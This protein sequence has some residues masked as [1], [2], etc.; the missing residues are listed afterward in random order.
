MPET[1]EHKEKTIIS[2]GC[3]IERRKIHPYCDFTV[4]IFNPIASNVKVGLRLEAPQPTLDLSPE[5]V[6]FEIGETSWEEW[7]EWVWRECSEV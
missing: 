6:R 1:N 2:D 5:T 3:N 7:V 4:M